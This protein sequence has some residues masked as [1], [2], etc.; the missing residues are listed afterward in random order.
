VCLR[1]LWFYKKQ[2]SRCP[3]KK[4]SVL[5]PKLHT[6]RY[7]TVLSKPESKGTSGGWASTDWQQEHDKNLR[8]IQ[9][10]TRL[11]NQ[12]V[13]PLKSLVDFLDKTVFWNIHITYDYFPIVPAHSL[14]KEKGWASTIRWDALLYLQSMNAKDNRKQEVEWVNDAVNLTPT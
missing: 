10:Q 4:A 7:Q 1:P 8:N 11:N 14:I 3:S 2:E 9:L 12:G 5:S 6:G 13:G